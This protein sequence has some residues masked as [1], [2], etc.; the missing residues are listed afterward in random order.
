MESPTVAQGSHFV[1]VYGRNRALPGPT[2][3]LDIQS[4][5]KTASSSGTRRQ[6]MPS[7]EVPTIASAR[8]ATKPDPP[9]VTPVI[10]R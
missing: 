4:L 6:V 5:P 2:V 7:T 9:A 3:T 1:D 10:E 8:T